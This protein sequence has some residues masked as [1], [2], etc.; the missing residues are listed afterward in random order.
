M[1]SLPFLARALSSYYCMSLSHRLSCLAVSL[2]EAMLPC[3][4][5]FMIRNRANILFPERSKD[6]KEKTNNI[7]PSKNRLAIA[8]PEVLSFPVGVC[9][10][11]P[12]RVVMMVIMAGRTLV[13]ITQ[14]EP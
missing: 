5:I 12:T 7:F 1:L 4:K 9:G 3:N 8:V 13:M 11:R 14:D 10:S 2:S 6:G